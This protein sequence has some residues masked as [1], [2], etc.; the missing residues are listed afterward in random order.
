MNRVFRL[1]LT[2]SKVKIQDN[3]LTINIL[4]DEETGIIQ[5]TFLHTPNSQQRSEQTFNLK[6][7]FVIPGLVDIHCHLRDFK[8]SAKET[9]FTGARAAAAGG[10]TTVFDMPN[11]IPPMTNLKDLEK[12]TEKTNKISFITIIPYL[13]LNSE[14]NSYLLAKYSFFKAYFGE[15]TGNYQTTEEDIFNFIKSEGKFLSIHAEDNDLIELNKKKY[16]DTVRNHCKIRDPST[17]TKALNKIISLKNTLK[18]NSTIHFAHI[19]LKK[20]IMFLNSNFCSFEVTPHHLSLNQNDYENLGIWG[21]MNPPLRSQKE[22]ENLWK[23]YLKGQIPIIATDHAPHTK[24]EKL[25]AYLSGIPGLETAL[26]V[27]LNK[28]KPIDERKMDLIINTFSLN[29]RRL[30][31]LNNSSG[32]QENEVADLTIIDPLKEKI[33]SADELQTKCK[34]SPWEGKKLCGWPVL[35]IHKGKVSFNEI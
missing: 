32:I 7:K 6:G 20:S 21:K 17:E 28:L 34:W 19:T 29:P 30:M 8:E 1:L 13:L 26:A 2:N 33:V 18:S 31:R 23:L 27:V 22:Q 35:T 14:T 5:K 9:L 15:T 10:Y 4:I 3:Y 24:N 25:Q 12:F 16:P 11:K